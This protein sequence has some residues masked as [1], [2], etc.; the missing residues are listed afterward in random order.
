MHATHKWNVVLDIEVPSVVLSVALTDVLHVPDWNEAC[1]V[2][3]RKID[4]TGRFWMVSKYLTPPNH[5]GTT[6]VQVCIGTIPAGKKFPDLTP[7]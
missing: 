6:H 2:S 4:E 3:W 7:S 5:I 1:L